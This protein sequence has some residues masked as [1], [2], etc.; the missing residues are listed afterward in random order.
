MIYAILN[1]TKETSMTIKSGTVVTMHYTLKNKDGQTIDSSEGRDPLTYLHGAQNIVEGLEKA[2]EGMN[3][4][5]S[6][7]AV[8][9]PEEGY[10]VKRDDLLQTVPITQFDAP[11]RV[12]AGAEF[13]VETNQGVRSIS[14]KEV[15]GSDVVVDFNHPLAGETLFFDIDIVELRESTQEERDHGHVH[16]VGGHHH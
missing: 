2:L 3:A 10:G 11:D 12:K 8:V 4:G 7:K 1:P 5:D 15:N 16:G 6:V 9:S 13:Q 14:I